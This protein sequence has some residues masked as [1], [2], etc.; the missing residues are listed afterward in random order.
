MREGPAAASR[1]TPLNADRI[2]AVAA[3]ENLP[4]SI[5]LLAVQ[6]S[7]RVAVRCAA[8][9]YGPIE[10]DVVLPESSARKMGNPWGRSVIV[11]PSA[12]G[13]IPVNMIQKLF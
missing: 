3:S 5:G 9:G 12:R 7:R 4:G 1:H 13:S 10:R 11:E 8:F 6:P 2:V